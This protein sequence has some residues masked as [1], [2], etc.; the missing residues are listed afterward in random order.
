MGSNFIYSDE[1]PSYYL[2]PLI[3]NYL[4]IV[5]NI[6]GMLDAKRRKFPTVLQAWVVRNKTT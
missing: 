2:Y 6:A 5:E 3:N 1:F 4:I